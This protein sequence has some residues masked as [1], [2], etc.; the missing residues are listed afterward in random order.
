MKIYEVERIGFVSNAIN[1][2]L[3][4]LLDV[5][6]NILKFLYVICDSSV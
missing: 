4:R 1:V 6:N 3:V 5:Q 2:N